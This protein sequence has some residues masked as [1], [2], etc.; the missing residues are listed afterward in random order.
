[1]SDYP[2]PELGD[3]TPLE[4]ANIPTINRLAREGEVGLV[5]SIP[6]GM[7]AGSDVANLSMMGFD[8]RQCYTG[9]SP[10]EAVSM[11]IELGP[12]D[13]TYRCNLVTLE[14][15]A[16]IHDAVILDHSS[17]EIT[18]E[19]AHALVQSLIET[20]DWQGAELHSGVSYRHCLVLRDGQTGAECTPPHDITGQA[21]RG[22]L[23]GGVNG[24]QLLAWMDASRAVL[25][26][27]PVN[28]ARRA[29]GLNPANCCWFWG[30]GTRPKLDSFESM[31][32][33]TGGVVSAVDLLKGIGIAAEMEAPEV[34]GATGTLNTNYAGK[35]AASLD[36]LKRHDF[37]YM[38]FEGP[39]ECGHQGNYEEKIIAIE[40]LD[41]EVLQPIMQALEDMGEDYRILIAPDH[42]TPI[43]VKTHTNDPIPYLMYASNEEL[44]P[45]ATAYNEKAAAA[46]GHFVPQASS[47][48]AHLLGK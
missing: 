36:I 22:R 6:E 40:R 10:L 18:T 16:D 20:L 24:E 48:M 5:Q 14:D 11:G 25:K 30:E 41:S 26:D 33:T 19:E 17:G 44:T 43:A 38:H 3:K 31:Y 37:V 12:N 28:V 15:T 39:D 4:V 32:Q 42:A 46:T 13:V 1:M 23:P 47:L 45:H 29:K 27:H 35:V 7:P 8:P 2:I 34:K 9:R 21:V